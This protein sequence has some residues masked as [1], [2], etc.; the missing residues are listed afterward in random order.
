MKIAC[1]SA[2]HVPS[3]SANS[4]Q[5]MKAC[6]SLAQLGHTVHLLV[7]GRETVPFERLAGFYGLSQGAECKPFEVEW[8]PADP[9][10]RRYD[11]S[12][13]AVRKARRLSAQVVYAWPPQ[14]AVFALLQGFPVLLEL[15]GPPE[16]VL[17]PLVFRLF[18]M[19]KGRKRVLPITRA[20]ADIVEKAFRYSFSSGELVISPNGVDLDRYKDLPDPV[21]ARRRLGL[22]E[23]ITAGYTGHFYEGRGMG[24]LVELARRFP[25]VNFLWAGGRP[26]DADVWKNYLAAQQVQNINLLGF[27]ENNRLPLYQAAADILLMPYERQIAGSSG[28][29]SADYCSPMKMFEYMAC[30]RAILSSDLPVIHEVLDENNAV[31]CPVEAVESWVQSFQY[32]VDHSEKR[33]ALG[34]RACQDVQAYAWLERARKAL[35]GFDGD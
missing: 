2:S 15:H 22:P 21:E 6:Q 17:G 19:L 35:A 1:I 5:V 14:A 3:S 29:N 4:I 16:G 20:L 30:R 25:T 13:A 10:L 26:Q 31:L 28:G 12:L 9:H 27:I 18:L 23:G 24:L 7:P 34:Q 32:L 8:L 11:F 33:E